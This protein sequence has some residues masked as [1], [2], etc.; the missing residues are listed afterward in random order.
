MKD[1][2]SELIK[3]L[4]EAAR[5]YYSGENEIMS[6]YEYD[7]LYS[8]L[9]E[10]EKK[11]GLCYPNSPTRKVGFAPSLKLQKEKHEQPALSLDKTKDINILREW[12]GD[13]KGV[14][15]WKL[16]GLTLVLTYDNGAL[17]KAVTRGNGEIGEIVTDNARYFK[18]IPEKISF[19]GHLIVRGEAIITYSEFERINSMINSDDDKY[20]NPRNLASGTVRQ[21]DSN[22]CRERQVLFVAFELV[23]G[24]EYHSYI[25]R[26]EWLRQQGFMPVQY[27]SVDR[28]SL[29]DRISGCS[30]L[31][32]KQ[33][34]PSDGLVLV[35]EDSRL[36]EKLGTTG[37]FP[38]NAKAFKWQDETELTT[39]QNVEWSASRTG[40]I[41][42]VAI[43][44]PVELEG[45]TVSRA[46]V[47]NVS[48]IKSLHLGIGDKISVYKANMIIPQ[49]AE[50]FTCSDNL[51]IP[52]SCPVC[53]APTKICDNNGSKTLN[54]TNPNCLAK[55]IGRFEHFVKRDAMNIEGL[56]TSTLETFISK[57][58]ICELA[59]LY[60]LRKY[61]NEIVSIDGFG[62]K[63]VDNIL[64]AIEKSKSTTID[65]LLYSLG[66]PEIGRSASKDITEQINTPKE[67]IDITYEELININGVGD[68]MAN[69]YVQWFKNPVNAKAFSNLIK[70]VRI[71]SKDKHTSGIAGK[72]FVI[73]GSVTNFSNREELKA[74]IESNGGKTSSSVSIKTDYLI[75]NDKTSGSSKNKKAKELHI[76]IISEDEFMKLV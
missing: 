13:Y 60:S 4:N 6:N 57:N 72:I 10:L 27:W 17:T 15:S 28:Y 48:V 43:F 55:Q 14:L 75:N 20:K 73:T 32:K 76:P 74:Y 16:D 35:Y 41:N 65:R 40:L 63:A 53:G 21:L 68:I 52:N 3:K 8:E 5:E 70:C 26:F 51:I 18:G 29:E 30:K 71:K 22:M 37:K 1:R 46:S 59:D 12:L 9:E 58:F 39:L 50:N 47:H 56:A 64:E 45:T 66:I 33:D 25:D 7:K 34:F 23:T 31:V 24:C 67:L 19:K 2:I 69:N 38:R 49:I 42:P 11:T 62:E 36:Y 54:C 44:D 61:R